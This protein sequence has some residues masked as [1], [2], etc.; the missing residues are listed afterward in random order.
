MQRTP[1]LAAT[2]TSSTTASTF[3]GQLAWTGF[4]GGGA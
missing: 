1:F 2:F 3:S 4:S